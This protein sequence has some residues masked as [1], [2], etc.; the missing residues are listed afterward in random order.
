MSS[1]YF[2]H[3]RCG[4]EKAI[5]TLLLV[6]LFI[7]PWPL[8]SNRDWAWPVISVLLAIAALLYV[9]FYGICFTASAALRQAR[10][11]VACFLLL[12]IWQ[13]LQSLPLPT[14]WIN[15]LSTGAAQLYLA[16]D[17]RL[18]NVPLSLDAYATSLAWMKT[19]TY[20]LMFV[21]LL[22]LTTNRTRLQWLFGVVVISGLLQACYGSLMALTGASQGV[23]I[24]NND[25]SSAT[26]SFVNRNHFA[27]FLG[28]CLAMG[29]GLLVAKLSTT[30]ATNLRQFARQSLVTL[31]GEKARLRLALAM[32][33]IALV[34]SHS[35][36]GNSAFFISLLLT[37]VLALVVLWWR[38][39]RNGNR[40][41]H[42]HW[43]PVIWLVTSLMVIDI[44]IVGAWFGVDRVVERLQN[45]S[46]QTESRDEVNQYGMA[47]L[48]D[49]WLTGVGGGAYYVVLPG[50]QDEKFTG[51][52]DQAHNDYLQFAI[53][54]GVPAAIVLAM[55]VFL[56]LAAALKALLLRRS[57]FYFGV[58]FA[59]FMAVS[60]LLMHSFVDFNLQIPANALYFVTALALCFIAE[61]LESK[62][63]HRG[64]VPTHGEH[65]S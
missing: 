37:S 17:A 5:F 53:E 7:A 48:E 25:V 28:L 35:R 56:A 61:T 58:A 10:W 6:V 9:C 2:S 40:R 8:G 14:A 49:Y 41:H 31:L 4:V 36:M 59:G 34:L 54:L 39:K 19:L 23:F 33:V 32:M 65:S 57:T 27:G 29:T 38:R 45:T 16:T 21:L 30:P 24:Q 1:P 3:E 43:R 60:G 12:I 51:F 64:D 18:E 47:V 22:Q 62:R 42:R 63:Y 46:M 11:A 44:A 52:Y 13:V 50:Y 15:A 55:V 20:V 26:G